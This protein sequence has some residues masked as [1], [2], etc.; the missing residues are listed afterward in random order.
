MFL[1]IY[2]TALCNF[3]FSPK[4]A[5]AAFKKIILLHN[6][7]PLW[8]QSFVTHQNRFYYP[9][10][11]LPHPISKRRLHMSWNYQIS[12]L[13]NK[14]QIFRPRQHDHTILQRLLKDRSQ[15][16]QTQ[17]L[18]KQESVRKISYWKQYLVSILEINFS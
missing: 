12:W 2:Y 10:C 3:M 6:T 1:V 4:I 14:W 7:T 11:P 5:C 18:R 8:N 16:L 17:D 13:P 9:S 15:Q